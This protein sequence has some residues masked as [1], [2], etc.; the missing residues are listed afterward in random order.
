VVVEIRDTD[1]PVVLAGFPQPRF[2]VNR[3]AIREAIRTGGMFNVI[4][5]LR[6]NEVQNE[7]LNHPYLDDWANRLGVVALWDRLQLDAEPT[8]D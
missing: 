2:Y 8:Q 1:V 7:T 3:E 5:A 6:V 4:D